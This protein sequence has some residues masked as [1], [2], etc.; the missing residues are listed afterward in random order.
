MGR[1]SGVWPAAG[2]RVVCTTADGGACNGADLTVIKRHFGADGA[3]TTGAEYVYHFDGATWV[4]QAKLLASDGSW[5]DP[6]EWSVVR[7]GMRPAGSIQEGRALRPTLR[8]LASDSQ[9]RRRRV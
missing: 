4:E 8:P 7:P 3:A 9:R 5:P 6:F 2:P 1:R